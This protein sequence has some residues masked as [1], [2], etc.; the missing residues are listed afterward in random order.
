[1]L[2]KRVTA[3]GQPVGVPVAEGDH[4]GR[5]LARL[6]GRRRPQRVVLAVG[7]LL[8]GPVGLV[9]GG[10]HDRRDARLRGRPRAGSR[11][12]ARWSRRSPRES[13]SAVP[14]IVCAAR[15]KTA[16]NSPAVEH[17]ARPARRRG[18]PLDSARPRPRSPAAR[19]PR[20][21][22]AATSR[23]ES[24]EPPRRP[25]SSSARPA[26]CDQTKPCA[27]GDQGVLSDAGSSRVAAPD[28]A[29]A[30]RRPPRGR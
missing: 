19:A 24:H 16:S 7:Q 23:S 11:C 14:T 1:M 13:A 4:V 3:T 26:R 8:V 10:D 9:R 29:R 6:V 2:A 22:A 5:R 21:G 17:G 15:W 20:A 30:P 27:A 28:F 18:G 25:R 12:R